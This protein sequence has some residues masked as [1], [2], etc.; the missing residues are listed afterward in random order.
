MQSN[1]P[2]RK[3]QPPGAKG[4]GLAFGR[5]CGAQAIPENSRNGKR[6]SAVRQSEMAGGDLCQCTKRVFADGDIKT[7]TSPSRSLFIHS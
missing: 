6:N 5:L 3:V 4:H 7:I 1:T 2:D